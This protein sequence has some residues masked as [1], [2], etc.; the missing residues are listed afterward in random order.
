MR[1]GPDQLL[2]WLETQLGLNGPAIPWTDRVVDFHRALGQVDGASYRASFGA[3]AW[4][5]ASELL[6]R[7]DA[8][9]MAG[10]DGQPVG[11]GLVDDLARARAR[12]PGVP[13]RL[14]AVLAA[15]AGGMR[16]GPHAV[17]LEEAASAWPLRWQPVLERL[18]V[19][20]APPARPAADG[21]T[22]LAG[23][24]SALLDGRDPPPGGDASLRAFR[25]GSRN[26]AVQAAAKWVAAEPGRVTILASDPDMA[27]LLDAA[28]HAQGIGT[29]GAG[30]AARGQPANQVLPLVLELLW[31]PVD[32]YVL[33]DFLVLPLGPVHRDV[34]FRLARALEKQPGLGS[35]A[36]DEAVAELLAADAAVQAERGEPAADGR[37]TR[38]LDRW[39]HHARFSRSEA[40]PTSVVEQRCGL[41]AQ[42]ASGAARRPG[43]NA[44]EMAALDSA[45]AQASA[46]GRLAG[47]LGASIS[48]AQLQR[49]LEEV[50]GEA[51]GD[52]AHP[53]QAGGPVLVH[54]LADVPESDLLVWIGTAA[55]ATTTP[56]TPTELAVLADSG[57][58]LRPD[59]A[60]RRA[61]Q[62]RGLAR[63]RRLLV[64]DL[65]AEQ[66][67]HPVWL[68]LQ[69]A[70]GQVP[71]LEAAVAD[72]TAALP[73]RLVDGILPPLPRPLWPA[74]SPI[75]RPDTCSATSLEDQLA[76][77]LKWTLR[78]ALALRPSSIASI[79]EDERLRGDF[80]HT[81]LETVFPPGAPPT[82]EAARLAMAAAFEA[83]VGLDAAPLAIPRKMRQRQDLQRRLVTA[84]GRLAE[85][86]A[87]GGYEIAGLEVE[88]G[89]EAR[90]GG[91]RLAGRIDAVLT[92][93]DGEAII[94]FKY[95]GTKYRTK[96]LEEGRAVQLATYA[97]AREAQGGQA[98]AAGYLILR[99]SRLLTPAAGALRGAQRPVAGPDVETTWARFEQALGD[100]AA[101]LDAGSVPARPLQDPTE[102]DSGATVVL[103]PENPDGPCKYCD[104]GVLCGRRQLS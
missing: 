53:A 79:P 30:A 8:L 59:R 3:D 45:S 18:S 90:V 67:A 66:S 99:E 1:G 84:A 12:L 69:A 11:L 16:L 7:R 26:A 89:D 64:L 88:I 17:F 5:T 74:S 103:D 57:I 100:A 104:Y 80:A 39:F 33:L 91:A 50:R 49:L 92:G 73:T 10:W 2:A 72:G 56:W 81:L 85:V 40:L 60:G 54:D 75:P 71:S 36:W 14:E 24:Q 31:E 65:R 32:P 22:A 21:A 63:A 35:G 68:R 23:V 43:A 87:A 38:L 83:R 48:E 86:L 19:A 9:L 46:L 52:V 93:P 61:A 37:V 13:D 51:A 78:H 82:P 101:W 76:C 25:P 97:H 34:G 41:V 94:D 29:M 62:V 95:G 77:P 4:A 58:H 42:W 28:L 47:S 44:D 27:A 96:L 55:S 6:Q 15:L 70:L 98:R 20:E 102:W